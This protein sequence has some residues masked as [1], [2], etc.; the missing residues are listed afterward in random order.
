MKQLGT[1]AVSSEVGGQDYPDVVSLT[2][3]QGLPHLIHLQLL[4]AKASD[5]DKAIWPVCSGKVVKLQPPNL[6]LSVTVLQ[7]TV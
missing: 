4:L 3:F 6:Y 7:L 2:P 1:T 5:L